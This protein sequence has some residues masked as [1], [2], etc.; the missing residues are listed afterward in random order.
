MRLW[1]G[2]DGPS[3]LLTASRIFFCSILPETIPPGL[4]IV[5][6]IWWWVLGFT[7]REIPFLDFMSGHSD[8][9]SC[10]IPPQN[11]LFQ[12]TDTAL[13]FWNTPLVGTSPSKLLNEALKYNKKWR[14]SRSRGIFPDKLLWER[15]KWVRPFKEAKDEGMTPWKLLPWRL[16]YS[17]LWQSPIVVGTSPGK[18][19]SETSIA[20]MF[21]RLPTSTN[22]H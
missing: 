21:F 3:S 13:A 2:D 7:G 5:Q 9:F 1:K 8:S 15:S 22:W 4:G 19:F 20:L 14:F 11:L 16:R 10:R 12:T 6:R 17:R 18:L